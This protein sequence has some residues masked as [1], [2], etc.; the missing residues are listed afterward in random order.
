MEEIH[1]PD[2]V[3]LCWVD[4]AFSMQCP[5]YSCVMRGPGSR[6]LSFSAGNDAT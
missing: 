5:R 4:I 3:L 6:F 1:P 2:T